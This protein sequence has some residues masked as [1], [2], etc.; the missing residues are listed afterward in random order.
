M[1]RRV[2]L[3]V[4]AGNKGIGEA[5]VKKFVA[6][7][8]MVA[9]IGRTKEKLDRIEESCGGKGFVCDVADGESVV[10]TLASVKETFGGQPVHTV[11]YNATA[12]AFENFDTTQVCHAI[13][14][15]VFG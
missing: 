10:R 11:I 8:Y 5:C 6:E 9:F 1:S 2:A 14:V 3:V 15:P 7:N 13:P 12:G 4:G